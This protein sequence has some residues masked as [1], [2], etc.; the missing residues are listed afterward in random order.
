VGPDLARRLGATKSNV[1]ELKKAI[2]SAKSELNRR[3]QAYRDKVTGIIVNAALTGFATGGLVAAACAAAYLGVP[4]ASLASV[5]A[6]GGAVAGGTRPGEGKD[7]K[8][9]GE[10]T[11]GG[12]LKSEEDDKSK[13]KP[14]DDTE[15]GDDD[16]DDENDLGDDDDDDD[17]NPGKTGEKDDKNVKDKA[18]DYK[19]R[20]DAAQTTWKDLSVQIRKAKDFA[21]ATTIGRALFNKLTLEQ[22]ATLV[23]MIQVAVVVME[24]ALKTIEK[25]QA[26]LDSLIQSIVSL[27]DNLKSM[28]DN[29][30]QFARDMDPK[31]QVSISKQDTQE[32]EK[33]WKDIEEASEAWLDVFNAQGISPI[34]S[35][36]L[37]DS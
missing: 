4:L 3:E 36:L 31:A 10:K 2:V 16:D 22:L 26:P 8:S 1:D 19:K 12:E 7:D 32:M 17:N 9:K 13:S 6:A 20:I 33:Q 23:S 15:D 14:K 25:I 28:D 35:A 11:D 30:K 21:A 18:A 24:G 34:S 27:A 37:L 29:C 5:L